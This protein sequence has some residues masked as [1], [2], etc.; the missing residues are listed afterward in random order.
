MKNQA[1]IQKRTYSP[2]PLRLPDPQNVIKD[3]DIQTSDDSCIENFTCSICYS[4]AWDPVFCPKCD[5]VFCRIC[6]I[7]YGKF[8]KCPYRC[9][10]TGFR[11]ITRN[12]L[13]FLDKISLKCPY[14]GCSKYVNYSN[15][16][17]HLEKCEFRLY[18]CKNEPCKEEGYLKNMIDHSKI[19]IYRMIVCNKCK[20]EVKFCE[21]RNH[22]KQICPEKIIKCNLCGCEMKREIYLKEHKSDNNENV[23]CLKMQIKKLTDVNTKQINY[24]TCENSK[25]KGNLNEI[26]ERNIVLEKENRNLKF[27]LKKM[28]EFYQNGHK[29]FTD[30]NENKNNENINIINV[31]NDNFKKICRRSAAIYSSK[32]LLNN[33]DH[34]SSIKINEKIIN[35]TISKS[36]KKVKI[37]PIIKRIQSFD[38]FEKENDEDKEKELK[39]DKN[40]N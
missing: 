20:Q 3:E 15:Y 26:K 34:K 29:I 12:E 38:I 25:I 39:N 30:E 7:N 19:C 23:N 24:L 27:K 18:H 11:E 33:K 40:N 35:K 31:N 6:R 36:N 14:E 21:E 1:Q 16:K 5:N 9:D 4:L 13:T 37:N 32:Q 10:C 8:N 2:N 17:S 28:K 22:R